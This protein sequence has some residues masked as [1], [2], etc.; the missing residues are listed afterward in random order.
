LLQSLTEC[1]CKVFIGPVTEMKGHETRVVMYLNVVD[2]TLNS[3]GSLVARRA[4]WQ[5]VPG[6]IDIVRIQA[7]KTW[8]WGVA[9]ILTLLVLL[10]SLL[11][12]RLTK[13]SPV[14]YSILAG[15]L[16]ILAAG[17]VTAK[18]WASRRKEQIRLQIFKTLPYYLALSRS[19][20]EVGR[21][22]SNPV[23]SPSPGAC[24]DG[25]PVPAIPH[26]PDGP[27]CGEGA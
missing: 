8:M 12:W 27:G 11:F 23:L 25:P 19:L 2:L 4:V 17:V 3:R 7:R 24:A 21:Q 15:T 1:K 9:G 10:L 13:T 18:V 5:S 20:C 26:H 14:L 6:L 22:S 16:L